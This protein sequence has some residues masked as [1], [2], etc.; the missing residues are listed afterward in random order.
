MG[1]NYIQITSSALQV[2]AIRGVKDSEFLL[3][4]GLRP[5]NSVP[6]YFGSV[7]GLY[8]SLGRGQTCTQ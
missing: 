1:A 8:V 4:V 3:G 2:G 5:A 7:Y 6:S